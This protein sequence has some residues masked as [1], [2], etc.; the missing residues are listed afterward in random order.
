M[1]LN[2]HEKKI[3][4]FLHKKKL[5]YKIIRFHLPCKALEYLYMNQYLKSFTVFFNN[6]CLNMYV[7]MDVVHSFV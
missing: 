7:H 6:F 5:L 4:F 3:F 1:R 2:L